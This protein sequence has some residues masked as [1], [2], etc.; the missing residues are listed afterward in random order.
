MWEMFNQMSTD[1][2]VTYCYQNIL[3]REPDLQGKEYYLKYLE[4]GGGREKVIHSIVTSQEHRS[5]VGNPFVNYAYPG[6]FN[7]PLPD[8]KAV[9][10]DA[11]NIRKISETVLG[12][13]LDEDQQVKLLI[14][15][16]K[17]YPQLPWKEYSRSRNQRYFFNGEH[18][19]GHGDAIVLYAMIRHFKPK[20]IIEVGCGYSSA[21][22]LDTCEGF[23]ENTDIIFIDPYQDVLKRIMREKDKL[24]SRI[25]TDQLQNIDYA[26]FQDL[27]ENDILFLDSSHTVKYSSDVLFIF[28]EILPRLKPGVIVHFHD[29][30]WPFEYPLEWL[31]EGR[32]WNEIYFLRSFLQYNQLFEI[33]YFNDFMAKKHRDE[34]NVWMPK[35][36]VN[37]GA[38]LWIQRKIVQGNHVTTLESKRHAE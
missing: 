34:L 21:V 3:G 20:R 16:S 26:I 27:C 10:S 30:F 11:R 33:L 12:V 36:L 23:L 14:E 18:W 15:F 17:Y 35:C 19:Y 9:L 13:S 31:M 4:N 25:I 5:K 32:A 6:H 37:P 7:S 28:T 29:I 1:A 38:G 2:F 8:M 22:M 24:T